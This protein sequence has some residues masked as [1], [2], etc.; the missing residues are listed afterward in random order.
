MEWDR[1]VL[2][3]IGD[4]ADYISLHRYVGNDTNNTPDY[5]SI[6]TAIDRQIE[7][8]DAVCRYVQAKRRSKKRTHL[9]FDEWNV[10]YR[11]R[12]IDGGSEFAPHL[13][14]EIYNLEDEL[15]VAEFLN[16]FIRHAD[17][18]KIANI[19]QII[20]V[21]APILTRD[22]DLLIQQIFIHLK[23]SVGVLA[24]FR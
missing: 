7:E 4:Y 16:S 8:M 3:S 20:N 11:N 23:W 6:S 10:W 9:C 19:A 1:Q 14:E 2:E 13:I 5:L 24:A 12:E 21:I 17:S 15:V 22:D 18:V